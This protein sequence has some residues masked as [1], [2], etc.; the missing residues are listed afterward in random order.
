MEE[1]AERY[2][3]IR[4]KIKDCKKQE[5]KERKHVSQQN[6]NKQMVCTH[7][8]TEVKWQINV[9]HAKNDNDKEATAMMMDSSFHGV[10]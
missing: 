4:K 8:C 3:E 10:R 6:Q 1:E 7:A 5:G 2:E 9:T